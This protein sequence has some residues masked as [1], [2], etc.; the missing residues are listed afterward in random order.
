[1]KVLFID[2]VHPVLSERLSIAGHHCEDASELDGEELWAQLHDA[3][4]IVVRGRIM[5]DR[6]TLDRAPRLRFIA[7]AGAGMENIDK[8]E[9]ELRG[10]RLYN[11]PEGNSDAVGEHAIARQFDLIG[12]DP[13]A[14][15]RTPAMNCMEARWASSASAAWGGPWPKSS[16]V[17]Q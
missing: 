8:A 4:G 5:F 2:A 3:E 10:I 16:G 11:S 14:G 12:F 9:C 1:M 7:R 6:A 17:S 13:R 15:R